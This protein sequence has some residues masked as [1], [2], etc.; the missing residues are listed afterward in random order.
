MRYR[1]STFLPFF[2]FL[3]FGL[4]LHTLAQAPRPLEI[5]I[6]FD[7]SGSMQDEIEEMQLAVADFA[8][9]IQ[10]QLSEC[11]SAVRFGLLSFSDD[12][13]IEL[14][15]TT[16]V[17]V[18]EAAV[19][20]LSAGDGARCGELSLDAIALAHSGLD[21]SDSSARVYLIVT[22]EPA[23]TLFDETGETMA[24]MSQAI[25]TLQQSNSVA[26]VVSPVLESADICPLI[27]V[28]DPLSEVDVRRLAA[29][30]GGAW[31]DI[32][33]R[34][35]GSVL[36]DLLVRIRPLIGGSIVAA[37]GQANPTAQ[38][39]IVFH[40][41][42]DEVV[43]GFDANSS[44]DDDIIFAGGVQVLD[45][46]LEGSGAEYTLFVTAVASS[47]DLMPIIPANVATGVL[48]DGFNLEITG[49][50]VQ[51]DIEP[52]SPTIGRA[53]TQPHFT[54]SLPFIFDVT[55][56]DVV[57]GFDANDFNDI[58]VQFSGT[59]PVTSYQVAGLGAL[60]QVI[61]TG[62]ESDG[63]IEATI[64]AGIAQ[65]A[66]GNLNAAS[67]NIDNVVVYDTA[68]PTV[69]V[70]AADG[71]LLLTNQLP[72]EFD[73]LFAERVDGFPPAAPES[74]A[75][76][77][78]GSA[79]GIA[80]E[81]LPDT[82]FDAEVKNG[83]FE[84]E[85]FTPWIATTAPGGAGGFFVH[86]PQLVSP[87][88]TQLT[89]GP[90]TGQH[91][92]ISDQ[93]VPS[94]AALTQTVQFPVGFGGDTLLHVDLFVDSVGTGEQSFVSAPL[95]VL[96]SAN[97]Y[98]T[99]D[100][101]RL[102]ASPFAD[103]T[104]DL[105]ANLYL[106]VD[107]GTKPVPYTRHTFDITPIA[108][109]S[110]GEFVLRFGQ[111]ATESFF[112]IDRLAFMTM[113]I[114]NVSIQTVFT[115]L[116]RKYR[117]RVTAIE[118]DGTVITAIPEESANDL[119]GNFSASSADPPIVRYD[120]SAPAVE[121]IGP[122]EF[123][124]AIGPI[125]YQ[126]EYTGADEVTLA[127][128]DVLVFRTG[129]ADGEVLLGGAGT[130]RRT[131]T[132]TRITGIG[133]I[134]IQIAAD[135]ARDETGNVAGP[136]SRSVSFAVDPGF[137]PQLS[138]SPLVVDFGRTRLGRRTDR[139]V[140][141]T[142]TGGS[143]LEG[144]AST[145]GAF[146]ITTGSP[147]LLN[148]GQSR[149]A[150]IRFEPTALGDVSGVATFTGGGGGEIVLRGE[151]IPPDQSEIA[152]SPLSID[153]GDVRLGDAISVMIHV[154]NLGT[155]TL[156]GEATI[157]QT[158][159]VLSGSPYAIPAGET[160]IVELEFDP[161]QARD[162]EQELVLT[163]GG[164]ATVLVTGSA[165]AALGDLS[166]TIEDASEEP[167]DH[168]M[169][170]LSQNDVRIAA[171]LVD[172]LG[173]YVIPNLP[174]G[175]Y[176]C[177]VYAAEFQTQS[178]TIEIEDRDRTI[179]NFTMEARSGTPTIL[180]NV[181][182]DE[183][184]QA[185]GGVVVQAIVDGDIV[186]ATVTDANGDYELMIADTNEDVTVAF[187]SGSFAEFTSV[188]PLPDNGALTVGAALATTLPERARLNGRVVNERDGFGISSA[189]VI[190][191]AGTIVHRASTNSAGNFDIA[192]LTPGLARVR[193]T[194]PE[195]ES[196]GP[197]AFS[198]FGGNL[199]PGQRIELAPLEVDPPDNPDTGCSARYGAAD[200]SVIDVIVCAL[201]ALVFVLRGTKPQ[202]P[203]LRQ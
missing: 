146:S 97:Q 2:A 162:Y 178:R 124:T 150:V 76:E 73:V 6:L 127:L 107:P 30:T 200:F 38:L 23:A 119:A 164:G 169:I 103:T 148:P 69:I 171:M 5:A 156:V 66:L 106:G 47:G 190:V 36:D 121:I 83:G 60:Y 95:N 117:I 82:E 191:S 20:A 12:F 42:F 102:G 120:I 108:E 90:S 48:C 183:N 202:K 133:T 91:L 40:I 81:V 199:T 14:D 35:I 179:A 96:D 134:A 61:V 126:I 160:G 51:F 24:R 65:D 16:E 86:G 99:V 180:G 3:L 88:G 158:F 177:E 149:E 27:G 125:E 43:T 152:V 19:F 115:G 15:F 58:D 13:D 118:T 194:A 100:L 10:A 181:T 59:A 101:L 145:S 131:V 141:I 26:F 159:T 193:V 163:G 135:T 63:I 44:D 182:D 153:F 52:P 197:Q 116:Y 130:N 1:S 139:S 175:D 71:Q 9:E 78:L 64:P 32:D 109:S 74:E 138:V 8:Q 50:L 75:I 170:V 7:D 39:P 172:S 151:G 57:T 184:G 122:S 185:L 68:P 187:I 110:G 25:G 70:T 4:S 155:D 104:P 45:F 192:G 147:Y 67:V 33:N 49:P 188:H 28:E 123:E 189:V 87:L 37:P 22:D 92:A 154:A 136:S 62:V 94:G 46:I 21:W 105:L 80:Y 17:D 93:S 29:A 112:N 72:I 56:D 54:N 167:V 113:G 98:G 142:N 144:N 85:G 165:H 128:D 203:G 18:L 89:V 31:F 143:G 195:Y 79:V 196:Y 77:F 11:T 161:G 114:D 186:A 173:E 198:L 201:A 84:A 168:A 53:A 111:V 132:I 174:A 137:E 166:G 41:R 55:F 129:S 176:E 157:P 140:T 34:T